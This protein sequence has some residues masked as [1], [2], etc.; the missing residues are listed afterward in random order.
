[1]GA[2]LFPSLSDENLDNEHG[3]LL[4]EFGSR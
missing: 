3:F 2:G 1:V 4:N